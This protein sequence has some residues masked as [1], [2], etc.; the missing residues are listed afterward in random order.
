MLSEK[1][2]QHMAGS[3]IAIAGLARD[4]ANKLDG[5]ILL[6]EKLRSYFKHSVVVVVEN[7]S[8]DSTRTKLNS[9]AA[10][11]EN[12]KIIDGVPPGQVDAAAK[13][14]LPN[15]YYSKARIGKLAAL[16]NQY[17]DFLRK[18]EIQ[19]DYLLVLDFDVDKISL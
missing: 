3:S 19:F 14:I 8:K 5:N 15:P 13:E 2:L 11:K 7:G 18:Q 4:C 17:I 16:R 1:G 9:W 6:V 12:V 10:Q